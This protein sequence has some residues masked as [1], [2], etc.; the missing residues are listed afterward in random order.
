M[1]SAMAARVRG[2]DQ[3][4]CQGPAVRKPPAHATFPRVSAPSRQQTR[5]CDR[6]IGSAP[7]GAIHPRHRRPRSLE[8]HRDMEFAHSPQRKEQAV[9]PFPIGTAQRGRPKTLDSGRS[10]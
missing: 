5:P 6:L 1:R 7:G 8:A 2:P 4:G 9:S 3:R 10:A